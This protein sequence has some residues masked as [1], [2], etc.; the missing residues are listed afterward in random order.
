MTPSSKLSSRYHYEDEDP[1]FHYNR[2]EYRVPCT[3][4]VHAKAVASLKVVLI[5]VLLALSVK[6]KNTISCDPYICIIIM[7]CI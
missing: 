3:V 1:E 4:K 5:I 2:G 7:H 6:E